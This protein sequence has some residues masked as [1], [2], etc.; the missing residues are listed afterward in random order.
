VNHSSKGVLSNRAE[1]LNSSSHRE[2]DDAFEG[3]G[4]AQSKGK[5]SSSSRRN[6]YNPYD[7]IDHNPYMRDVVQDPLYLKSKREVSSHSS[8]RSTTPTNSQYPQ[9]RAPISNKY[10]SDSSMYSQTPVDKENK[11]L[12]KPS[13]SEGVNSFEGPAG[14]EY[15]QRLQE[16][17][18]FKKDSKYA[19]EYQPQVNDKNRNKPDSK[20][21]PSIINDSVNFDSVIHHDRD[22]NGGIINQSS[23]ALFQEKYSHTNFDSINSST[24]FEAFPIRKSQAHKEG[25]FQIGN[26]MNNIKPKYF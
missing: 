3:D 7:Q 23:F 20:R 2:Y 1:A 19:Y 22:M 5:Q 24:L 4:L 15:L 9:H 25:D 10:R 18:N 6:L 14:R 16:K 11:K 17:E 21:Q 13:G 8:Q 26:L 12:Y